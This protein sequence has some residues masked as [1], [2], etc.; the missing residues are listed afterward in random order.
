[1]QECEQQE[2]NRLQAIQQRG[3]DI[4]PIGKAPHD[5]SDEDNDGNDGND[6]NDDDYEYED[7][8][9]DEEEEDDSE[10]IDD[11]SDTIE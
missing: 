4:L 1:M 9:D 11:N 6:A 7:H 2:K 10:M 5:N 8:D 3:K